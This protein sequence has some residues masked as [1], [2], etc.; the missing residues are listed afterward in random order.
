[1]WRSW[2]LTLPDPGGFGRVVRDGERIV[3]IVEAKDYD[4]ALYGPV[5]GEINAGV[6]CLRLDAVEPL[7]ARLDTANNSGEYYITD[8]V[9]LAVASGLSVAGVSC[10]SDPCLLGINSP[11]E[12]AT[13]EALL[14]QRIVGRVARRGSG[15][16]CT[17]QRA[18]RPGRGAGA[19]RGA[20]RALR[21]VWRDADCARCCGHEP[22]LD[23]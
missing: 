4:T 21:A 15:H 14:R 11:R 19:G 23:C 9:G 6:Y 5:T 7:L 18:H 2:T 12:L 3:G 10:G 22:Y 20:H 1:M 13:A 16:S 8:L 17:G